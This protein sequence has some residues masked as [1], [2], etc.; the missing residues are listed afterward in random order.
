[1]VDAPQYHGL[2]Q[3]H[4]LFLSPFTESHPLYHTKTQTGSNL[5]S[6]TIDQIRHK[7]YV[8]IDL[9]IVFAE[10]DH[11]NVCIS[12]TGHTLIKTAEWTYETLVAW[13]GRTD[14]LD[15][16]RPD[17]PGYDVNLGYFFL[18]RLFDGGRPDLNVADFYNALCYIYKDHAGLICPYTTALTG[19]HIIWPRNLVAISNNT[20]TQDI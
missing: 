18:G 11:A 17:D 15:T 12:R 13:A 16:M 20:I 3:T 4:D 10:I 8:V 6:S 19:E 2:I 9:V 7:R 5:V 14:L 1:M